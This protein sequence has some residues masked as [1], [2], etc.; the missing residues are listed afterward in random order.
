VAEAIKSAVGVESRLMVGSPGEFTVLVGDQV[1]A[2][3]GFLFFPSERKIVDAVRK[4][5]RRP[6]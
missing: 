4:A 2:E 3:K 5:L 1:V 6:C